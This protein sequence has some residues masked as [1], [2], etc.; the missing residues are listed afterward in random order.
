MNQTPKCDCWNNIIYHNNHL[1]ILTLLQTHISVFILWNKKGY[2][3]V[4]WPLFS[5]CLKFF[6]VH[7]HLPKPHDNYVM[8]KPKLKILFTKNPVINS[9]Q[10]YFQRATTSKKCERKSFQ[11][12]LITTCTILHFGELV[13]NSYE[14][15]LFWSGVRGGPSFFSCQI[16]Y[17]TFV[18]YCTFILH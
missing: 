10:Q 15:V 6:R 7:Y 4:M 1:L 9:K 16:S 8:N 13:A 11:C 17:R 5:I 12:N 18:Q 2:F 14:F 3:F